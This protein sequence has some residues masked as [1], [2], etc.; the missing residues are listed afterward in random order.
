[1]AKVRCDNCDWEGETSD[2]GFTIL[3]GCINLAE[4]LDPGGEVP[5]GDCPECRCFCYLADSQP[6]VTIE[7]RGGVASVT[8]NTGATVTIIDHDNG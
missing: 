3:E 8:R 5:A 6:S 4:R 1:M 2:Q 7:V